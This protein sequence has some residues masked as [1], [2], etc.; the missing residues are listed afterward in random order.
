[1]KEFPV[2][3]L[4]STTENDL[5]QLWNYFTSKKILFYTEEEVFFYDFHIKVVISSL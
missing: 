2:F 5:F 4:D 3:A 1:M